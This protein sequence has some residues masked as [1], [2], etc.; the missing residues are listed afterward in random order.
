L[1]ASTG[2]LSPTEAQYANGWSLK[3]VGNHFRSYMESKDQYPHG[4][5]LAAL[6]CSKLHLAP[7]RYGKDAA[8]PDGVPFANHDKTISVDEQGFYIGSQNLYPAGLQELGY[9]VDDSRATAQFLARH[10]ANVWGNAS[11]EAISGA[12]AATCAL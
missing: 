2:G 11:P 7:L 1:N 8:W 10:W 6:L 5:A 9:I 3:D 4:D 12:G